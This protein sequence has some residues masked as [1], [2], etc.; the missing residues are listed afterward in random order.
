MDQLHYAKNRIEKG[1]DQKQ[2]FKTTLELAV[3]AKINISVI[4]VDDIK[5]LT[6]VGDTIYALFMFGA[7]N[8]LF[9]LLLHK[10]RRTFA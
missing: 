3:S 9:R 2:S 4:K 1:S 5:N 6:I 8:A 10:K 7:W